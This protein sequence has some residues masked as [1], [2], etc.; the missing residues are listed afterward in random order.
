MRVALITLAT[1]AVAAVG[2]LSGPAWRAY[3]RRHGYD[4]LP[5]GRTPDPARHRDWGNVRLLPD[6]LGGRHDRHL[7]ADADADHRQRMPRPS[8]PEGR[9]RSLRPSPV[10]L[11]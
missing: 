6:H 8:A 9:P 11:E 7:L 10:G 1:P 5:F 2:R 3:A 4:F